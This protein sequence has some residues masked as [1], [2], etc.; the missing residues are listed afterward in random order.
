MRKERDENMQALIFEEQ[1]KQ[2]IKQQLTNNI[3]HE[4]KNPV[5]AI[6]ACLETMVNNGERLTIEQTSDLV[7]N[8]YGHVKQLSSLL[9]DISVITRIS[10]APAQIERENVNIN[11]IIDNLKED[12]QA[13]PPEKRMRINIDV[14]ENMIIVGNKCLIESIFT[15]LMNNALAYSGGRDIYI[16]ATDEGSYY[17]YEFSDNGIGVDNEHLNRL[18]ERFYRIDSGRS[19]KMGGT[20]LGLSIVKNSVLF[21]EGNIKVSNRKQGGLQFTFTL[22]K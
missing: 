19:R 10:E 21:H 13:Y 14:P 9:Q 18:F 6:Q 20:G 17:I 8:A 1:E 12:M 3:N 7:K 2:R 11:T 15:N 4:I 22:K 5:H 16:N